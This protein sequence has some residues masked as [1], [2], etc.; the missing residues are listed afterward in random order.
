MIDIFL[1]NL[2]IFSLAIS[3]EH[4]VVNM[5]VI[6]AGMLLGVEVTWQDWWMT[7]HLPA[8]LGNIIGGFIFTAL[9]L[10]ITHG[11]KKEIVVA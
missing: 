11:R 8:T 4:A 6:P 7:N 5:F 10:Y 1:S 2:I 3:F 9:A